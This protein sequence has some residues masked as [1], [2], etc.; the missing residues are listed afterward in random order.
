MPFHVRPQK[1]AQVDSWSLERVLMLVDLVF[2]VVYGV[3][4]S[5]QVVLFLILLAQK[6]VE[7]VI[8]VFRK[9]LFDRMLH[10]IYLS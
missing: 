1:S 8:V 10:S 7:V 4:T 3:V 2:K 5:G 6:V 9:L